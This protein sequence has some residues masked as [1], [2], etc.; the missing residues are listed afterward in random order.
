MNSTLT[1]SDTPRVNIGLA[2]L[3]V[4]I[5]IIFLA[6]GAQKLFVFGMGG[7]TGAF[8]QM[9][10]PFPAV[11]GPLVAALEV[12]GGIALITGLFTRLA[13]LGLA[14][15]MLGAILLVR[16]KGGF[17]N[18]NGAEFELSLFA[19]SLAL[20][21]AGPGAFALGT[22]IANRRATGSQAT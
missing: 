11:T 3:R 2:V 4:I 21:L 5:G 10:V 6:H 1:T 18:P 19:A 9:G 8:T 13:A 7:V 16:M 20:A 14:I 17:F 22:I 12:L 15:D